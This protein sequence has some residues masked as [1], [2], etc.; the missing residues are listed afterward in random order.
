ML[1]IVIDVQE[2]VTHADSVATMERYMG[3]PPHVIRTQVVGYLF[4]KQDREV[5]PDFTDHWQS[6]G[7]ETQVVVIP[8]TSGK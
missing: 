4:H 6:F 8:P 2:L 3:N 1:C 5:L 7:I